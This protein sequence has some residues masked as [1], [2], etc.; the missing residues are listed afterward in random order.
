MRFRPSIAIAATAFATLAL[1]LPAAAQTTLNVVTAGDQNMVDY[2]NDFLAP[3]FEKMNPGVKV[4]AVGTGPGDSGSQKIYEKLSAQQKAG[5][6][7][8]DTDVAVVHQR[9]A[10]TMVKENLLMPY[11]NDVAA[12]KLVTRDT[13]KNALGAN[14]D[15]F[16]L[17]MFHSQIAFAYNPDLVKAPPKSFKRAERLGEEE[18]EAVRLQRRQG[19]HVRRRL[20]HGLGRGEQRPR[21]QAREGARTI[22]RRRRRSRSRSRASRS[23]TRAS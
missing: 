14:V 11:R 17:P 20:R 19:R 22:R 6:A 2:V 9:G 4:R 12:G 15:G 8:W 1:S 13:A 18:P 16:V 21:R 7:A 10:A 23:S 3:R 5:T